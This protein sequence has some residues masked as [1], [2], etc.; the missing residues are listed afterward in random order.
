MW[1]CPCWCHPYLSLYSIWR[2]KESRLDN[3][4]AYLLFC[5][6]E[7]SAPADSGGNFCL[8]PGRQ[9][10]R[11]P[12][13]WHPHP[14]T[15]HH[16]HPPPHPHP[17]PPLHVTISYSALLH[18][19]TLEHNGLIYTE[20]IHLISWNMVK[21][22]IILTCLMVCVCVYHFFCFLC[23]VE[24]TLHMFL[25]YSSDCIFTPC[26]KHSNSCCVTAVL[27]SVCQWTAFAVISPSIFICANHMVHFMWD[28]IQCLAEYG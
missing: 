8:S 10:T 26:P 2:Q 9:A 25:E 13:W 18:H 16:P 24:L 28:M 1:S 19:M 27:I 11:S 22:L 14:A 17:H 21:S 23:C 4:H 20:Y 7:A 6:H 12:W 15:T 3:L 5:S